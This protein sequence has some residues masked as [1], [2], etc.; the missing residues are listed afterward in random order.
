MRK[1]CELLVWAAK[2]VVGSALFA[3]GFDLFL[4]PNG[5]NAGGLTGLSMALMHLLG[6]GTVGTITAVANLP[7]FALGAVKIGRR[8]LVGSL[9]GMVSL[10][11]FIDLFAG[12]PVPATEPL[13]GAIYG[14]VLCGI[15]LGV[16]FVTGASTGGSDI[17]VR[18]LKLR[19]QNLSIGMINI[20]FDAAVTVLTGL[21][22]R[23][24]SRALYSG[25]AIYITG[26][27]IDAVVYRFDDSRVAMI[28]SKQHV[29]VAQKICKDLERGVTYLHGRGAYSGEETNVVLTAIKKQQLAELKKLVVDI[30]PD[31]FVI[32][33]EAHQVL[34]DGFSRYSK[35]AL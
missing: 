25:I 16:V 11:G 32:V 8:F 20:I 33:Q 14:S 10:T 12:I 30:D 18:L 34:G 15:G 9:I 28:I 21:V 17:L 3:L 13:I 24:V 2:L 22:F 7:L 4:E 29:Q 26:K 23:D 27:I 5:L 31:A 1:C 35:D 19:W 6:F